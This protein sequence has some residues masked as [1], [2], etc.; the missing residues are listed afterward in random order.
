MYITPAD[1]PIVDTVERAQYSFEELVDLI[2]AATGRTLVLFTARAEMDDC[3]ERLRDLP[4]AGGFPWPL[5]VQEPG[6]DKQELIDS[7][8]TDTH[9]VLVGSK[10]FFTGIDIPGEALSLVVLAKFPL[11]K[12]DVLCRRQIE[13]WRKRKFPKWYER[14]A[15]QVFAQSAGRLIRTS[16]DHGLVAILDQRVTRAGENV[17]KTAK[18]GVDALGSGVIRSTEDVR[19]FLADRS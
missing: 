13:H 9:S 7:F 1:R 3:V 16:G 19:K 12:F 10:S 17:F 18:L 2:N 14:E 15:L 6:I 11:P 4:A 8:K 5:L